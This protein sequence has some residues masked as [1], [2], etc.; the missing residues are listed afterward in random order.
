MQIKSN[1]HHYYGNKINRSRDPKILRK[2]RKKKSSCCHKNLNE[3]RLADDDH[4]N[5]FLFRQ[6]T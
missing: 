3:K 1:S 4:L 6:E 2:L 5:S